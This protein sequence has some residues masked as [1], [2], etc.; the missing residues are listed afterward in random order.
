MTE[1]LH[2]YRRPTTVS[3]VLLAVFFVFVFCCKNKPSAHTSHMQIEQIEIDVFSGRPNPAW[4][5]AAA[6]VA[7]LKEHLSTEKEIT[8]GPV[9]GQL[10]YRGFIITV[11]N[12]GADPQQLRVYAGKL[13]YSH[14][15]KCYEDIQLLESL[16]VQQAKDNGFAQLIR[17]LHL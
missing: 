8:C 12:E 5:P 14:P 13:W 16:L 3:P 6:D 2:T 4:K 7:L 17:D 1:K 11:S 9:P 15:A 10:G